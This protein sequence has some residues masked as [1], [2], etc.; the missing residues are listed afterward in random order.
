MEINDFLVWLMS[1]G[2]AIIA[3]S[4]IAEQFP[5]W[6][7]LV[8]EQRKW[9][10][11]GGSAVLALSAWAVLTYVSAAALSAIA[12]PFSLV[13]GVFVL[14]FVKDGFHNVTK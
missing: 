11:F 10:S 2:G 1:S 3:F 7:N 8:S 9:F 6:H 4:W 14:V 12:V 13:A 5:G